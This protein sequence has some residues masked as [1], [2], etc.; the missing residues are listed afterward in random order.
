MV[1]SSITGTLMF[2]ANR[3]IIV[4]F[5]H[6]QQSTAQ[7]SNF[8]YGSIVDKFEIPL[9]ENIPGTWSLQI[10]SATRRS[11]WQDRFLS[12]NSDLFEA[13]DGNNIRAHILQN[14]I[15]VIAE[16]RIVIKQVAQADLGIVCNPQTRPRS[17][18]FLVLLHP[19]RTAQPRLC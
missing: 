9:I 18:Q 8:D 5:P 10:A 19:Y 13:N 2:I 11:C 16:D 3:S 17:P 6:L 4:H 14:S 7:R 12:P 1:L 15:H